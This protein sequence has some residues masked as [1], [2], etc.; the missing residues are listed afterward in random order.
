MLKSGEPKTQKKELPHRGNFFLEDEP[1]VSSLRIYYPALLKQYECAFIKLGDEILTDGIK[2]KLNSNLDNCD[3]VKKLIASEGIISDVYTLR[4]IGLEEGALRMRQFVQ[5]YMLSS[6]MRNSAFYPVAITDGKNGNN[7][8]LNN[9]IAG[10][11][12]EG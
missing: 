10:E 8:I 9:E 7:S 4:P 12:L 6:Q 1:L 2:M 11:L 5:I 3:D